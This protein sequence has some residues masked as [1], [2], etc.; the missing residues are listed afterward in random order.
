M[1][2][3]AP[4]LRMWDV[5][6]P[7]R[8]IPRLGLLPVVSE[9]SPLVIKGGVLGVLTYTWRQAGAVDVACDVP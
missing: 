2:S 6:R 8:P 9:L 4:A 1:P 5:R 7:G 3:W